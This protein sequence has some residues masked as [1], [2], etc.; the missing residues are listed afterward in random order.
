MS[1]LR[2][3][4][5]AT[6]HRLHRAEPLSV[7]TQIRT[8]RQRTGLTQRQFAEL[9]GVGVRTL[10]DIE[11]GRVEQPQERTL[12]SLAV[13]LGLDVD[14]L[15]RSMTD[16]RKPVDQDGTGLRIGILG[17]LT[18]ERDGVVSEVRAFKL[19][20]LLSLLALCHPQP[21]GLDEIGS[22]LWPKEP[23]RSYQNLIHTYVSQARGLLRSP[24]SGPAGQATSYLVRTPTGYALSLG[25]DQVDL[26]RF[27]GLAEKARQA[28]A[29]GEAGAAYEFASLAHHCWR[30]PI[31][32]DEP[33][34]ALHPAATAAVRRRIE[35]LLLYADLALRF[36]QPEHVVPALRAAAEDEPLHEGLQARLMLAL[37]SCGEQ[38]EA[39]RVFADVTQRLDGELGLQPGPELRQAHLRVLQQELTWPGNGPLTRQQ[40]DAPRHSGPAAPHPAPEVRPS[41]LPART[42]HFVGRAAQLG[43]LDQLFLA[44]GERDGQVPAALIT[45]P[46]GV[47]KTA[48]ALRW[49]HRVLD[50]FPDGQLYIDLHGHAR[51]GP[52]DALTALASFLRA[53]GVPD[54]SI[55]D[56][57]DEAANLFR[58]RLS[59]RRVLVV[60]DNARDEDQIR[61]LIPG[62]AGCAV[63]VTSRNTLPG[64]VARDGVRRVFVDAL[65]DEDVLALLG[66][67]LGPE[68]VGVEALAA[69]AL[70]RYCGG[71]PLMVR[72]LATRLAQHPCLSI[73]QYYVELQDAGLFRRPSVPGD[74]LLSSVQTAF[75]L[76]YTALPEPARRVFRLLG[77]TDG[78]GITAYGLADAAGMTPAE[79][80]WVLYRLVDASL[81]R[82]HAPGRFSMSTPLLRYAQALLDQEEERFQPV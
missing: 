9:A 6:S 45:G 79:T 20:R 72:I 35:N 7:R 78:N 74:L 36:Q 75:E 57:L 10:R 31:L 81:L 30:G 65:D 24:E 53:L 21:A 73:A 63:L 32:A 69:M 76:S 59:G 16:M 38:Y 50:R 62:D 37:A 42:R 56:T 47:G 17:A 19:R 49:A 54:G 29:A 46:P 39:L 55:P 68:R 18:I 70:G 5:T 58:T 51:R 41:Q 34:L 64:L 4:G 66:R 3:A 77:R 11:S 27:R 1:H 33:L 44:A 48:L 52:L 15:R 26:T 82:E 61:P 25:R 60:L 2:S 14:D 22:T 40:A 67:L 8:F 80:R 23:P 28:H 71:L 13:V 12:R 43:D